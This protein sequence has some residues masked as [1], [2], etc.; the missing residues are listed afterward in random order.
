[1]V[2][3]YTLV[4]SSGFDLA[5]DADARRFV[6]SFVLPGLTPTTAS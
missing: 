4:P 5:V 3:S 1:M 2:L 6:Q